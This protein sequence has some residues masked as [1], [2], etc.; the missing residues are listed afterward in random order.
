MF[1]VEGALKIQR[2]LKGRHLPLLTS[3]LTFAWKLFWPVLH[4]KSLLAAL[5]EQSTFDLGELS[6][7]KL[8]V[9]VIY[10]EEDVN[11]GIM[12]VFNFAATSRDVLRDSAVAVCTGPGNH[13]LFSRNAKFPNK[14][15]VWRWSQ[16]RRRLRS[17]V[18]TMVVHIPEAQL[19]RFLSFL[20]SSDR[21]LLRSVHNLRINVLNQ[22]IEQMPEPR[23][24]RRLRE[25]T[26]NVSQTTAHT[27]YNTQEVADRYGL[28][29]M[30][31][32]VFFAYDG[33]RR[34]DWH[35]KQESRII[36]YSPDFHPQKEAVLEQIRRS[37]PDYK[38]V[39][40]WNLPFLG[41]MDLVAKAVA[42]ITFGEGMDAYFGQ[43]PA[44]GTLSFA[45]FNEQFFPA[46]RDWLSLP[47]LFRSYDEMKEK[48]VPTMEKAF[49]SQESYYE[50]LGHH[51]SILAIN[52]LTLEQ[53]RCNLRRFY[54]GSFDFYPNER[55]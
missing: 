46:D 55:Q 23:M 51:Q 35:E 53:Y 50:Y 3:F 36:A 6:C 12:S 38:L 10:G 34:Y 28:P 47:T 24:V 16:I 40:I 29:T 9:F 22:N 30:W 33:Y 39:E 11:G 19:G 45:V 43:P 32:G 8:V 25:F 21:Q 18:G 15:K 17:G 44:V 48:I 31:V 2:W 42:V 52:D 14:E 26:E 27:R 4:A 1:S 54:E 13:A 49:R 7:D 41:Y 5:H 20:P 37:M